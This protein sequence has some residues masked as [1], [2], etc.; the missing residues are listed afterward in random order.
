[1]VAT[2]VTNKLITLKIVTDLPCVSLMVKTCT[3]PEKQ[4]ICTSTSIFCNI[5]YLRVILSTSFNVS[6]AKLDD[7]GLRKNCYTYAQTE[8]VNIF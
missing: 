6:V 7:T 4:C 1:M 3:F 5:K 2:C 8:T